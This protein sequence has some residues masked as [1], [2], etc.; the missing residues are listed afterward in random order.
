[1]KDKINLEEVANVLTEEHG[2]R[3]TRNHKS[4]FR[5][6]IAFLAKEM[7]YSAKTE[8]CFLAK[9]VVIGNPKKAKIVLTA[10]YD[11]P[12]QLPYNFIM[13]QIKNFGIGLPT[14]LGVNM[15]ATDILLK[16]GSSEAIKLALI[17]AHGAA[18]LAGLAMV[19]LGGLAVYSMGFLGGENQNNFDDNSS[20]VL[21]LIGLMDYYK[22]LPPEKRDEV[23]FVFFDNEEKGLIGSLCYSAKHRL[24]KRGFSEVRQIKN[25]AFINYDCVGVGKR[26]NVIYTGNVKK[27]FVTDLVKEV[28]KMESKGYKTKA[29]KSTLHSM[30]DHLA[31]NGSLGN[32]TILCDDENDPVVN[33]IHSGKDDLL[34]LS[35]VEDIVE[36]SAKQINK[37]LEITDDMVKN[38]EVKT[39]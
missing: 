25:Q 33:H 5:E 20:G 15:L 18:D 17:G 27:E 8:D 16:N 37:V 29:F 35:N 13:K 19:G 38:C 26:V 30:S 3:M 2:A 32:V 34:K 7:G 12:P 1:M 24:Q 36:M 9:N 14:T 11:T 21:T 23:A 28:E 10:H 39:F 6:W 22:N 31:F 4:L